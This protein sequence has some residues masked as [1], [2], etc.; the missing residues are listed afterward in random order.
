M[1]RRNDRRDSFQTTT[2]PSAAAATAS[3]L[4]S[5]TLPRPSSASSQ[6]P[7]APLTTK[8]ANMPPSSPPSPI[9]SGYH[10]DIVTDVR[11]SNWTQT[12]RQELVDHG[13]QSRND[14]D[15]QELSTIFQE[16]IQS[17]LDFRLKSSHAGEVAK[18]I[19]GSRPEDADTNHR[20]FDTHTL[21]LDTLSVYVDVESGA[22]G[23]SLRDFMIATGIDPALMRRVLEPALLE[24][25]GLIRETFTKMGIRQATNILYKQANYNLLREETEG[26]SKLATELF[27]TCNTE[28]PTSDAVQSAFERVKGLIGTFDLDVGRVLDVTLDVFAS[29]LIKQNRFFVKFLRI[30]SW[31]PRGNVKTTTLVGGLP[32]WALPESAHWT[33]SDEDEIVLT[34]QRRQRDIKFW[35][36]ARETHLDAYFELGGRQVEG[37]ELQ[38]L[39]TVLDTITGSSDDLS[40]LDPETQW[41]VATKTLPPQGNSVAAQL[42][43]FKLRFYE[44]E[45]KDENDELPANIFFM[46]ALLIKIGFIS[47]ADLWPHVAPADEDMG[48]VRE[49]KMKKLEEE[50]RTKIGKGGGALAMLGVLPDDE[51]DVARANKLNAELKAKAAAEAAAAKTKSTEK[52]YQKVMLLTELLTLGAIPDALFILARFPWLTEAFPDLIKLIN[53]LLLHS[54]QKVFIETR[55]ASSESGGQLEIPLKRLPDIDQAGVAKGTVRLAQSNPKRPLRW[56][57]P[58]GVKDNLPYRCYWDEW[59]D[60]VPVCQTIDDVF[61]LCGTLMNLSGV[62]IGKDPALLTKLAGIG[63]ASLAQDQSPENMSRWQDLLKRLLVPALSMT[64]ANSFAV[65]AVWDLLKLYPT[66]T[67][68]NIYA[69]WF[70]GQTSRSPA[71]KTAFARTKAETT[72]VLKRLSLQNLSAM[73]KKLAKTAYS[74]PGIVFKTAFDQIEAYPNLIQAF[75]ECARYLTDLGYDV[76]TWSLMSALGGKTRSRTQEASVLLT[77]KW[78]QALSKFSGRVFKRYQNMKP[79]PVLQYVNN[80]LSKGN[81]TDLVI[82]RELISTMGGVVSDVDFTDA[83]LRAM[84]GGEVLR[85]QTLINLGDRR[86]ESVSGAKRLMQSLVDTKLAGRLLINLSQYRQSAPYKLPEDEAHVKYLATIMDEVHQALSQYLD[87]LRSN[88]SPDEFDALIPSIVEL[89][90]DYGLDAHLAF[91]I[92]RASLAYRMTTTKAAIVSPVKDGQSGGQPAQ[93]AIDADGDL[94]MNGDAAVPVAIKLSPEKEETEDKMVLDEKPAATTPPPTALD[95]RKS[96]PI[97]DVLQPVVDTIQNMLPSGTWQYI[98]PEFYVTFWS[99]SLG[100][101]HVPNSSYEAEH[102]RLNKEAEDVMKDRSD[103]TRQGMNKKD[104]KKRYLLGLAKSIRD[105]MTNHIERYQKTKFRLARQAKF[106][107]CGT[108]AEANLISDALLEHCILPRLLVSALDTEYCFRMIKFLHENQTPNFKLF[109][110]YE[111]LFNANRLRAMIFSCTMR[112]AEHLGRLIKCILED[113]ARWHGDKTV[114]EKEAFGLKRKYLGFA[115]SFDEEGNPTSFVEHP[116]FRDSHYEWHKNLNV[117]LK[118]CLQGTK[119]WMHIRNAITVLKAVSNFFPA[120]NFMGTQLL[121]VLDEIKAR[122]EASKG[123]SEEEHR[124]DLA[125][126]AQTVFSML[127]KRESKWIAVPAFRP[128]MS[129]MP[130]DVPKDVEMAT[131]SGLRPTAAEFN[132]QQ[133]ISATSAQ[134]AEEEDG[135]VKD[136]KDTKPSSSDHGN[137]ARTESSAAKPTAYEKEAPREISVKDKAPAHSSRSATPKPIVAVHSPAPASSST[138]RSESRSGATGSRAERMP[139]GLPSRPDVPIPPHY[140]GEP[141]SQAHG[142]D[143]RESSRELRDPKE[144]LETK[145]PRDRFRDQIREQRDLSRDARESRDPRQQDSS[146]GDKRDHDLDRRTNERNSRDSGRLPERDRSSRPEPSPRRGDPSRSESTLSDREGR[147]PRERGPSVSGRESRGPREPS[148]T[149][150]QPQSAASEA[151]TE[152]PPMNPERAALLQVE[153]RTELINPQRAALMQTQQNHSSARSPRDSGRDR[154]SSRT[155]SPRRDERYNSNNPSGGHSREDRHPRRSGYAVE[156][157]QPPTRDIEQPREQDRP[158]NERSRDPSFQGAPRPHESDRSRPNQQDPNYGRLNP[159]PTLTDTPPQGPRG[160]GGRTSSKISSVPSGPRSDARMPPPDTSRAASPDRQPPTG[161][162]SSRSRRTQSTQFDQATVSGTAAPPAPVGGGMHPDRAQPFEQPVHPDRMRHLVP[163]PPPPPP[164]REPSHSRSQA[165]PVHTNDRAST[166]TGPSASRQSQISIP[167]A[168]VSEH[169]APHSAPTGPSA[170]H[171][172]HRGS[173]RRQLE[174][175]QSSITQGS[176]RE[177]DYRRTRQSMPDSDAQILTGASP[178]STPVHERPDPMRRNPVPDR[179]S[180]GNDMGGLPSRDSRGAPVGDDMPGS[181][182]EHDRSGRRDHRERS[183]RSSRH[184]GRERSPRGERDMKDP[185]VGGEYHERHDRRA[186]MPPGIDAS[187]DRD[188]N[189]EPIQPRRS[190]REAASNSSN[191]EPLP[192]GNREPS[193]SGRESRHRGDGRG[194]SSRNDGGS[195]GRPGGEWGSSSRGGSMRGGLRD[196]PRDVPREGPRDGP[197]DGGSGRLGDDRRDPRGDDRRSA[198]KRGSDA[199]EMPPSDREKRPRR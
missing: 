15:V 121:K 11:L 77:S 61:T 17:C 34:E 191:R 173:V 31:W 139:H 22:F 165:V 37:P 187:R 192:G 26:Y 83:Q 181:R 42:L 50:E 97:T 172:R 198:R 140:R 164:P 116:F 190:T 129:G 146:R 159:I 199:A 136:G 96:D 23:S 150:Q 161:P 138:G 180:A 85:R 19:L 168:P 95:L 127:K 114:Y 32:K 36:R 131:T 3:P 65:H 94:A 16:L 93:V 76:L 134:P 98:S 189:H 115:T 45:A 41:M 56:P 141:F 122:E 125:V 137:Q 13:I 67:R 68:Y 126:T 86:F 10:Y 177:N 130:Q 112:E 5:P 109:A 145:N 48:Q 54:I 107:F 59:A 197:R 178:I 38:R 117:A 111:Q 143:R 43:G 9:Q 71:I 58:D 80:Q 33:T 124:V 170:S 184:G 78:L 158:S 195:G 8:T 57:H 157:S 12:G 175:L 14:E 163:P 149:A 29:V 166:P 20:A 194:D 53:R 51:K 40:H 120:V 18:D 35:S 147:P 171:D 160:R 52:Y 74:S 193:G 169:N 82:L 152:E 84:T 142:P 174:K 46:T 91:M 44:S 66:T 123:S 118:A 60:N 105:E 176:K 63:A 179:P 132:P 2:G 4:I 108:I 155:Q 148:V 119:E 88:V 1:T 21:L 89:I 106:W 28:P 99:L 186:G 113:L 73:A 156:P 154:T 55:T 196:G 103:M 49:E 133:P 24:Q 182:G 183:D 75:V 87:F 6:A 7:V 39:Q 185:R 79:S 47:L 81:S 72:S 62:S 135:E 167:N 30:S 70:L 110:F 64:E 104:E 101:L 90:T 69:E 151:S 27:T 144:P 128:N 153:D 100:D 162:S 188:P 92:G 25:L 102:D